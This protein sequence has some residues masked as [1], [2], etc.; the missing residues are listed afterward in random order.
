MGI[1]D[2]FFF[3]REIFVGGILLII[4]DI[5]VCD[6]IDKEIIKFEYVILIVSF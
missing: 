6:G 2:D 4:I 5:I 1:E 3:Y